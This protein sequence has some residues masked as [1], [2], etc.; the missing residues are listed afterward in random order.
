MVAATELRAAP[1]RRAS[2]RTKL[3][4]ICAIA[5][6][7][8]AWQGLS[9]WHDRHGLFINASES[10]PNWAFL[11]EGGR[12]PKR[13]DYVL[14]DPG[15]DPLTVKHFGVKPSPFA[16]I[17]YGVPGDVVSHKGMDVLINGKR[18]VVMKPLTH[19]GEI[20]I[21]GPVGTIPDHCIFAGTPHKDGFD[22]RYAAIGFVCRERVLGVG[23]PIL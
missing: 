7:F 12:F 15:H 21:Q 4:G 20:L 9:A 10:L 13:G 16:K 1:A 6:A 17:A 11:V 19:D 22:S 23:S 18:V 8:G 14:L 3:I 5:V 2:F